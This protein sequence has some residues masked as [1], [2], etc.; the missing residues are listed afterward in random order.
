VSRMASFSLPRPHHSAHGSPKWSS[1]RRTRT[2]GYIYI[3][4]AVSTPLYKHAQK[5]IGCPFRRTTFRRILRIPACPDCKSLPE[6]LV[7]YAVTQPLFHTQSV[8]WSPPYAFITIADL[9]VLA[10]EY[11]V[12]RRTKSIVVHTFR[13]VA[14]RLRFKTIPN[15][16]A[17][18][19]RLYSMITLESDDTLGQDDIL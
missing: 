4:P 17:A 7:P 15:F 19:T 5:E 1:T 2:N 16:L 11:M 18:A 10:D 12:V 14:G 13:D 8:A 6:R 3:I 9:Y